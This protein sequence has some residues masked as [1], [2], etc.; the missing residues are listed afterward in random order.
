[1]IVNR[2]QCLSLLKYITFA[3]LRLHLRL[4][5]R[6]L[7]HLRLRF[8]P[9]TSHPRLVQ[10][11]IVVQNVLL[12]VERLWVHNLANSGDEPRQGPGSCGDH[13]PD[14]LPV[15]SPKVLSATPC[16]AC[17]KNFAT[18]DNAWDSCRYLFF[19][20]SFFSSNWFVC[21]SYPRLQSTSSPLSHS[22]VCV[23]I[24]SRVMLSPPSCRQRKSKC[25]CYRYFCESAR[26]VHMST[27]ALCHAINVV[28]VQIL[29]FCRIHGTD[30]GGYG[31]YVIT[32]EGRGGF[33]PPSRG[34]WVGKQQW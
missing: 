17:G 26:I 16:Q 25:A 7:L 30:D 6:Y 32:G 18:E 5:L 10:S 31:E 34:E 11:G 29:I 2:Y 14:P 9:T 15:L 13:A 22:G 8:P 21:S 19:F 20:L 4:H 23:L 33:F 1:M 24:S 12:Q 3:Y 28:F 27:C